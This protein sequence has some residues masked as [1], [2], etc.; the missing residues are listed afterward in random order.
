MTED[1]RTFSPVRN[2][3]TQDGYRRFLVMSDGVTP[4]IKFEIDYESAKRIALALEDLYPGLARMVP[5]EKALRCLERVAWPARR[6]LEATPRGS[7]PRD[8]PP[9]YNAP[10]PFDPPKPAQSYPVPPREAVV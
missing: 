5:L 3:H 7:T 10:P 4:L 8:R 2:V 6:A 1:R 9:G